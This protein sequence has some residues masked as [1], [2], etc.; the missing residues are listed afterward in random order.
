[1]KTLNKKNQYLKFKIYLDK[2]S[3]LKF[4]SMIL[5][6]LSLFNCGDGTLSKTSKTKVICTTGVIAD[7]ISNI[8]PSNFEVKALMGPGVDPHIYKSKTSEMKELMDSDAII[9]NGIH[10]ESNL[11]EAI[12]NIG[13]NSFVLSLG[14]IVPQDRL[15]ATSE[16]GTNY[17]PH[18]WHD[19]NLF[20]TSIQLAGKK[21]SSKFPKHKF[22]I[23]SATA[24]YTNELF[25]VEEYV[26][27]EIK[28]IPD[29]LKVLIT[30]HDAFGYYGRAFGLEVRGV[31]GISTASDISIRG[32]KELKDF[33]LFRR[34]PSIFI[35]N[36]VSE[37]NIKS[38]IEGCRDKGL[39]LKVGGTLY[40]DGLGDKRSGAETYIKMIK[41][42]TNTIVA[43][44]SK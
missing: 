8:L 31:Q 7:A 23:D 12:N 6:T 13:K 41:K 24:A 5:I 26:K 29:S 28:T 36:S 18:F 38:V 11:I 3:L 39:D 21:L 14:D 40:S 35:E 10:F 1:M 32:I 42:N 20:A 4:A 33:I 30:A 15:R 43:A 2:I 22:H 9:Y 44:L 19:I 17:D 25:M 16:F 37:K 34:I 27:S